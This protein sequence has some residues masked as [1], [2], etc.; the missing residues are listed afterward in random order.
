[1]LWI[2]YFYLSLY[3]M[4]NSATAPVLFLWVAV[5][6]IM[7][8]VAT[9]M[10]P[11]ANSLHRVYRDRLARAF[12]FCPTTDRDVKP[13]TRLKLSEIDANKSPY[14]II[15]TAMNVQSS[16]EANRR[17]RNAD[18]FMFTRKAESPR[19]DDGSGQTVAHPVALPPRDRRLVGR[20]SHQHHQVAASR[21]PRTE[22]ST[23]RPDNF[24]MLSRCRGRPQRKGRRKCVGRPAPSDAIA[25]A[26]S[27]GA[28]QCQFPP[29]RA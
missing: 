20:S 12:L 8:I 15:N 27:C 24:I 25:A 26:G 9:M 17:G 1:M 5:L 14:H 29:P 21:R 18:F 22:A 11:N 2:S 28:R 23:R 19:R 7:V 13:L 3:V 4:N 16:A 10:K 6:I